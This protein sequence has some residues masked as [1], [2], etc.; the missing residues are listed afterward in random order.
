MGLKKLLFPLFLLLFVVFLVEYA[1][2]MFS[3]VMAKMDEKKSKEAE[4][5]KVETT[6]KNIGDLSV[7]L[8]KDGVREKA[9]A[10]LPSSRDY[11]L[12]VDKLNFLAGQQ[13]LVLLNFGITGE[14]ESA[15]VPESS[16]D[17]STGILNADGTES[18][19]PVAAP[20]TFSIKVSV[21]GQYGVKDGDGGIKSLLRKV[22]LMNRMNN[23]T[24]FSIANS[25]AKTE[26][27]EQQ[28]TSDPT[29]DASF[30]MEFPYLPKKTYPTAYLLPVFNQTSFTLDPIQGEKFASLLTDLPELGV[31]EVSPRENPFK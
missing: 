6:V 7:A 12:A 23:I 9:E 25:V 17:A 4:L 20:K 27:T 24:E 21:Q 13:G 30:T 14:Q 19:A 8:G 28:A 3:A 10:Y 26:G 11:A 2:P 5:Q 29:L 22:A 31:P 18:T 1:N 16:G 15:R